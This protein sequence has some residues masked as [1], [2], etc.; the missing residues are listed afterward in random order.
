MCLVLLKCVV[1]QSALLTTFLGELPVSPECLVRTLGPTQQMSLL[2]AVSGSFPLSLPFLHAQTWLLDSL[3]PS[4]YLYLATLVVGVQT[5]TLL[6]SIL[7]T[8]AQ[9]WALC[10]VTD[11]LSPH[12]PVPSHF[13]TCRHGLS[14]IQLSS[15]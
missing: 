6:S 12:P 13:I 7:P 11:F 2:G 1:Y 14:R 3:L 4:F 15:I 9:T 8:L 10:H 5:N